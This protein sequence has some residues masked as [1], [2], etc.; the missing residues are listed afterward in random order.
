MARVF[1]TSFVYDGEMYTAV[2][3]HTNDT[4]N[5]YVPDEAFHDILPSGKVT[6]YPE[7]GLEIDT[8]KLSKSQHLI[9]NILTSIEHKYEFVLN[10]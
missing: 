5:I 1:T 2:I 10:K 6:Y 4:I 3:S 9:L 7:Q 8:F